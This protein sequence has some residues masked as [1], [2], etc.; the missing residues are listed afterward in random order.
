MNRRNILDMAGWLALAGGAAAPAGAAQPGMAAVAAGRSTFNVRNYGAAGDGKAKD[1]GAIQKAIDACFAARGGVVYLPPGDYLSGSIVLKSN[2]TLWLEAGATLWG[3]KQIADY[4]PRNLI[5]ARDATNVG[6]AGPG[7]IDGNGEAYWLKQDTYLIFPYLKL[8]YKERLG[9]GD[10]LHHWWKPLDR[11]GP[12]L[13]FVNCKNV[14]IEDVLLRNA[15]GWTVRPMA[16]DN[17]LVRGVTIWNPYHGPNTDGIDPTCCRDVLISDCNIC[18]GDDAICLKSAAEHG[19]KRPSRNITVTNCIISTTCNAFKIGTGTQDDFENI[20]FSNS[21]IY[22]DPG[23]PRARTMSGIALESVD[24]GRTTGIVISNIVMRNVRSAIMLRLGNRGTGQAV[25]K[26]GALRDIMIDNVLATGTSMTNALTG[27]PGHDIENVRLS[28][29]AISTNEGGKLEWARRQIPEM[30]EEYPEAPMYGRLPSFGFYF[31]HV[32]NL[33]LRNVELKLEGPDMRPA[34]I[35][36][37]VKDLA[38]AGLAAASP[39]GEEPVLRFIGVRRALLQGCIAPAKAKAFVRL[40]GGETEKITLLGN[41][42]GEAEKAID[43]DGTVPP[44]AVLESGNRPA[45]A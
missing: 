43:R 13:E 39:S 38:I 33:K 35:C 34:V 10:I 19:I 32:N 28:N 36:D 45:G 14:R 25:P 37:D 44:N 41:D 4:N 1:T 8:D 30:P 22:N 42:F 6:V 23:E 5:F 18:T 29:I 27:L 20:T 3:S 9:W 24:G 26:P 17:V 40:E 11:P 7:T 21:V 16:C 12:M 15:S 31:R 2:V